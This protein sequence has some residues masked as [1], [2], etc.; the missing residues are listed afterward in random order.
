MSKSKHRVEDF[1]FEGKLLGFVIK[2]GYKIKYL[3]IIVG[4]VEYWIKPSKELRKSLDSNIIPGCWLEVEGTKKLNRK[5]GTIKYKAD[6]VALKNATETPVKAKKSKSKAK[7]LICQK[8][9]C[10]KRG[11]NK[12]CEALEGN[13]RD[14]GIEEEV[15][16]KLVGCLKEC[17]K[18]PNL[19]LMPDKVRYSKV[20]PKAVP[21]LIDKHL[22]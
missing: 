19:V 18:G 5:N 21:D 9:S 12:V 14:R 3:R 16:I 1:S 22:V 8:S 11:A 6:L 2:D 10:R 15:T 7:V 4:E 17:K 13:L 20:N